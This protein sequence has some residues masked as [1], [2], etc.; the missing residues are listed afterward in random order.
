MG[1]KLKILENKEPNFKRYLFWCLGCGNVHPIDVG[2]TKPSWNFNG[3]LESPTF[4][5]SLVCSNNHQPT[6]CHLFIT[7]GKIQ[8][9]N[10]C[11][12]NLKGQTVDM[13]D[14]N[15]EMF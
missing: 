9:L 7:N 2:N 11:W 6:R 8:Y 4:T 12:H 13:V 5:P 10:D 1:V 3:N 15:G 14:W